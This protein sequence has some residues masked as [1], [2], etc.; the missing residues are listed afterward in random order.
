M[1]ILKLFLP[2]K[3]WHL[4]VALQ[5]YLNIFI[6]GSTNEKYLQ[7]K[8]SFPPVVIADNPAFVRCIELYLTQQL[9]WNKHS[10]TKKQ[11]LSNSHTSW[12]K[13]HY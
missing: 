3:L 8:S 12:T 10:K 9:I 1:A 13:V 5:N 11:E 6:G 2:V 4:S 7:I